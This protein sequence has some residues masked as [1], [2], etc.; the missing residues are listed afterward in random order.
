[1]VTDTVNAEGA[2]VGAPFSSEDSRPEARRFVD[3]FRTR[4]HETPDGNAALAYDATMLIWQAIRTGGP[5]RKAI[6][7]YLAGLT[8]ETA[9][10]GVT[11]LIRFQENGDPIGKGFVMTR[12]RAGSLTMVRR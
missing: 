11:G 2:Y 3:A 6:R 10:H 7:A 12:V 9:H 5:T 8:D 1:M 4:Y